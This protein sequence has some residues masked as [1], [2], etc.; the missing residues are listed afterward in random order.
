MVSDARVQ[1]I[2][3]E[4]RADPASSKNKQTN[5]IKKFEDS[6]KIKKAGPMI[7]KTAT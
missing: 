6:I 4:A 3:R 2:G 7:L 1:V 5:K